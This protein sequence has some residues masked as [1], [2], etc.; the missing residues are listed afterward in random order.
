MLVQTH[1]CNTIAK[2]DDDEAIWRATLSIIIVVSLTG[3]DTTPRSYSCRFVCISMYIIAVM[4]FGTYSATFISF[5]TVHENRLPYTD[6]E[7]LLLKGGYTF[8]MF[9]KHAQNYISEVPCLSRKV[10]REILN[11]N[12]REGFPSNASVCM[13]NDPF[14]HEFSRVTVH[15]TLLCLT[16]PQIFST[17]SCL[18]WLT[19]NSITAAS[20]KMNSTF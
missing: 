10:W 15:T 19:K 5:L 6:L 12:I 7:S 13:I 17:P 18:R 8:G 16:K 9:S 20:M 4:I 3:H 2:W 11:K 14:M 1:I